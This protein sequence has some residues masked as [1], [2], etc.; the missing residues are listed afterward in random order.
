MWACMTDSLYNEGITCEK[1][2]EMALGETHC[3]R[4]V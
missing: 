3:T 4:G 2:S 1:L